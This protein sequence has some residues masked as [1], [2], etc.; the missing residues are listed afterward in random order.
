MKQKWQVYCP[1]HIKKF[2]NPQIF[3]KKIKNPNWI[4]AKTCGL[5]PT[6]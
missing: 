1:K 4:H 5:E 6:V 2:K 3:Y